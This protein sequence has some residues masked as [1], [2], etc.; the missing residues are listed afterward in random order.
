M[1]DN[2]SLF[3]FFHTWWR[4]GICQAIRRTHGLRH[5]KPLSRAVQVFFSRVFDA[6]FPGPL[7]GQSNGLSLGVNGVQ[8]CAVVR[9]S[10]SEFC[11]I[12]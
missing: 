12:T 11:I 3:G 6:M 9:V 7:H 2:I 10:L 8:V 1:S 4:A 5:D